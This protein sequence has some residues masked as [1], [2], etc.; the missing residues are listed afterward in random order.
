MGKY[1]LTMK[2]A[3]TMQPYSHMKERCAAMPPTYQIT[4]ANC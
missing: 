2:D 1:T 4:P 3:S